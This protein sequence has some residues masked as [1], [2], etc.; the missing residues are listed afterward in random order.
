MPKIKDAFNRFQNRLFDP[1]ELSSENVRSN[2]DMAN[3]L[4]NQV[5]NPGNIQ[6]PTQGL[7][8]LAQALN[9]QAFRQRANKG[10]TALKEQN[11]AQMGS[12]LQGLNLDPDKRAILEN[13]PEGIKDQLLGGVA[14]QQF[15]SPQQKIGQAQLR[16]GNEFVTRRTINGQV[17]TSDEGVISRSN[18]DRRQQVETGPP[19]SFELPGSR[20]DEKRRL[21]RVTEVTGELAES[22]RNVQENPRSTGTV[23]S[24]AEF[25]NAFGDVPVL[26]NFI[27]TVTEAAT[28]LDP[29]QLAEIRTQSSSMIGKLVPIITGDTSGR[30]TDREQE[31]TEDI[32]RQAKFWTT[33]AQV[34]GGLSELQSIQIRGELR[35]AASEGRFEDALTLFAGEPLDLSTDEGINAWGSILV[36]RYGLPED[37]ALEELKKHLAF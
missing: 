5:S 6:S 10:E 17:D 22:L 32:Q 9:A 3:T 13:A 12:F 11:T 25:A 4:L 37:K 26:G 24:A 33:A 35:L 31:R 2:R 1:G 30:Y 36:D 8:L 21:R 7:A 23:G 28:G 14:A 29:T 16:E 19:G 18:I 20:D 34:T 27:T 15:K